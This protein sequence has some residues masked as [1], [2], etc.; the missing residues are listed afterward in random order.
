MVVRSTAA[1]EGDALG[2][3]S[4]LAADGD[5][6]IEDPDPLPSGAWH[7]DTA[8]NST[9]ARGRIAERVV[10]LE[11]AA[12]GRGGAKSVFIHRVWRPYMPN[13][14]IVAGGRFLPARLP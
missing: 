8:I 3:G 5:G 1:V 10:R 6:A 2:C 11:R 12:C 9:I 13:G 14:S 7:P 4:A